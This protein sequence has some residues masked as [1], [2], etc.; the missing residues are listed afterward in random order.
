MG[1]RRVLGKVW[2]VRGERNMDW[3]RV[4]GGLK[5]LGGKGTKNVTGS[6]SNWGQSHGCI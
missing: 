1:K 5:L 3:G 2:G 4:T 6:V